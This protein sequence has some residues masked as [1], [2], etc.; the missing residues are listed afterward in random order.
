MLPEDNQYA[1]IHVY[2]LEVNSASGPTLPSQTNPNQIPSTLVVN[3]NPLPSYTG[4]LT[5]PNPPIQPTHP[6]PPSP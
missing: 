2:Q 1:K 4:R 6:H 5:L 3:P